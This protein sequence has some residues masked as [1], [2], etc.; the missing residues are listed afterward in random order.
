[1]IKV[2]Y[3]IGD[4]LIRLKNAVIAKRSHFES[5]DTKLIRSVADLLVKEGYLKGYEQLDGKLLV[6]VATHKK[7]P[8]IL[9][10]KLVSKPGLRVYM[11]KTELGSRH[12][13]SVLILSTSKGI[14]T[15]REAIKRGLGGE[16]FAQI[17]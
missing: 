5:L 16:V 6:N 15:D 1:M 11:S 9:D 17:W 7:K 13:P 8:I 12:G 2:D 14:M 10:I 3:P 4:F